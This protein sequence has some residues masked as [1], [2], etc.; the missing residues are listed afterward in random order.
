MNVSIKIRETIHVACV[1]EY[2]KELNPRAVLN[3]T[4]AHCCHATQKSAQYHI[5]A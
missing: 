2:N 4:G 5:V 3:T 1:Y